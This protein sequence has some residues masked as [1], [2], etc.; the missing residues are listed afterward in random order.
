MKAT[1]GKGSSRGCPIVEVDRTSTVRERCEG[2]KRK[3]RRWVKVYYVKQLIS[4]HKDRSTLSV[5][6]CWA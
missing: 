4:W 1:E 6:S 3:G 5:L 2:R